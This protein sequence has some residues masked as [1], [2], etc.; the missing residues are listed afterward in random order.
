MAGF[1]SFSWC[2]FAG[3]YLGTGQRA[4]FYDRFFLLSTSIFWSN[5]AEYA[6]GVFLLYKS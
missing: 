2:V 4:H 3:V 5:I 1:A 6:F